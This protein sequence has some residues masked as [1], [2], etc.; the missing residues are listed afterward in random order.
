MKIQRM[1]KNVNKI[2]IQYLLLVFIIIKLIITTTHVKI[3]LYNNHYIQYTLKFDTLRTN[4]ST[5]DR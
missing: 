5:Q 2:K 3:K 1:N 4:D